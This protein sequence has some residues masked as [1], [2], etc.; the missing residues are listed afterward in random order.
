MTLEK[1][2]MQRNR[3]MPLGC[4]RWA[5]GS[6]HRTIYHSWSKG[7]AWGPN[8]VCYFGKYATLA[9][10]VW[11]SQYCGLDLGISKMLRLLLTQSSAIPSRS[12]SAKWQLVPHSFLVNSVINSCPV[13]A[14]PV[15]ELWI[16]SRVLAARESGKHDC[17]LFSLCYQQDITWKVRCWAS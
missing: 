11:Y 15:G 16:A 13:W 8:S 3:E 17:Q 5:V 4:L 1:A 14:K 2:L 12:T 10:L 7:Q 9:Q 6:L